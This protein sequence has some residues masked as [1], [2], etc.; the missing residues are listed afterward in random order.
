MVMNMDMFINDAWGLLAL[1]TVESWP[2]E[3]SPTMCGVIQVM[4]TGL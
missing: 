4:V 3:R 1:S 2:A